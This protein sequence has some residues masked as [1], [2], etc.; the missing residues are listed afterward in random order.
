MFST[1]IL[2]FQQDQDVIHSTVHVAFFYLDCFSYKAFVDR[3]Q[4]LFLCLKTPK[5]SNLSSIHKTLMAAPYM[6]AATVT[7]CVLC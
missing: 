3:N 2:P 1:E 7:T 6:A 4:I 5:E